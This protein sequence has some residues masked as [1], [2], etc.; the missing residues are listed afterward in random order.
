M[1]QTDNKTYVDPAWDCEKQIGE[2]QNVNKLPTF[3]CHTHTFNFDSVPDKFTKGM[4]SIR[5]VFIAIAVLLFA[6]LVVMLLTQLLLGVWPLQIVRI[7]AMAFYIV[8]GTMV[9]FL[10]LFLF[11]RQ[12]SITISLKWLRKHHLLRKITHLLNNML[13]GQKYNVLERLANFVEHSYD[14]SSSTVK[15][16]EEIFNELRSYYSRTTRFVVL[17]MDMD[18]MINCKAK[19]G[20]NI[21]KQLDELAKVKMKK[22]INGDYIYKD[23]IFPFVHADPRRLEQ[24]PDYIKLIRKYIED[25]V[26][27]GIKIYPA[28]GY[29]PFDKRLKPVYDLALEYNLPITTHCSVGPV[30]YRGKLK[31]LRDEPYYDRHQREFI[32]PFTGR[33]LEGKNPKD[34]SPHFTHPMNYYCLM[35]MPGKL[36]VYWNKGVENGK[37]V[38][39]ED[40]E[41]YKNLKFCI[42]HFGGSEEWVKYLKDAWLPDDRKE[43][44]DIFNSWTHP[45]YDSKPAGPGG[46]KIYSW[47]TVI[48]D[49]LTTTNSSD[50][51]LFPNLYSDISFNVSNEQML[52][53]LKVRLETNRHKLFYDKVLFGTDFFMVSMK[54][55]EREITMKLRSYIGEDNFRQIAKINPPEFLCT[56]ACDPDDLI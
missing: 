55:S 41:K 8:A 45:V 56:G 28:L 40:L 52:P 34:F 13:P 38:K 16:Q 19:G 46:P 6:G 22:S 3:N 21:Y 4:V 5:Y 15:P 49:M 18:Y 54:A 10:L 44:V 43:L 31:T 51:P 26:Y 42:G 48:F 9:I 17:P 24:D 2:K 32:H 39:A 37:R 33:I 1:S 30:F 36:A 14:T 47:H 50:E 25:K 35:A 20:D 11:V 27:Q 29:F 53:L 23:K 7:P 12:P